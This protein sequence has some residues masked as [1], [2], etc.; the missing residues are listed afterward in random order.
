LI[1]HSPKTEPKTLIADFFCGPN[2]GAI[3]HTPIEQQFITGFIT[4]V[5]WL[6][7]LFEAKE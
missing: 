5:G 6:V 3:F 4:L 7:K 2:I 1:F